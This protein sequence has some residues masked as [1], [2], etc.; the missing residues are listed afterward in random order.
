MLF[1]SLHDEAFSV[2]LWESTSLLHTLLLA[3][4]RTDTEY[5]DL[6]MRHFI[7]SFIMLVIMTT[8]AHQSFVLSTPTPIPMSE[9][10]STNS[11]KGKSIDLEEGL[12]REAE[13]QAF[14]DLLS[15]SRAVQEQ[16]NALERARVEAAYAT[17]AQMSKTKP[18]SS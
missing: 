15:K 11:K 9:N 16:I 6:T 8:T 4:L 10:R 3:S 13:Y 14:E 17:L 18:S 2:S 1:T 12:A 7:A 5:S